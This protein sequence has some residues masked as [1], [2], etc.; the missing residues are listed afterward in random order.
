MKREGAD[1][2][3]VGESSGFFFTNARKKAPPLYRMAVPGQEFA[4][5]GTRKIFPE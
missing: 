2:V 1:T 4:N 3:R 5:Q